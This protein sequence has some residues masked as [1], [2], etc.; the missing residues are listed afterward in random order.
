MAMT[1]EAVRQVVRSWL[2]TEVLSPLVTKDE[3][4]GLAADKHGR[5]RNAWADSDDDPAWSRPPGDDDPTPWTCHDGAMPADTAQDGSIGDERASASPALSATPPEPPRIWFSVVLAALPAKAAFERL[6]AI[7]RQEPEEETHRAAGSIIAAS[8][9]LDACGVLVPDSMAVASFAWGL[10]H[11]L[12][13]GDPEHLALWTEQEQELKRRFAGMLTPVGPGGRLRSLT[14]RDLR[15]ASAELRDALGIPPALWAATPCTIEVTGKLPPDADILSSFYLPDLDRVLRHAA[16]LPDAA[17]RYLGLRPPE[18]TWNPLADRRQLS[19]LLQPGLFPLARWPGPGLHPLTLLQQAA[20][21]AIA[22]DLDRTGLAAVNGPPGT[23]KTTLLRDLVA[24]VLVRRA[25]VLAGRDPRAG[26]DGMDLMDFAIVVA[27]SNNAAVENVSLELPV[28]DKALDASIWSGEGLDYFGHTANAVL[29]IEPDASAGERAWGLMAARLGSAANRRAFLND[30][31]W[32]ENWGL[33][34]WLNRAAWP[35]AP[36]NRQNPPGKLAQADPPPRAPEAMADWRAAR[37]GFRQALEHCRRLRAEA[38][39]LDAAGS[40]LREA[41][42]QAPMAAERIVIAEKD[43]H[44]AT[45]AAAAAARDCEMHRGQELIEAGK[46]AA[47][48]SVRPSRLGRL[49]RTRAWQAHEGQVR[50]Q[51]SAMTEAQAASRAAQARLADAIRQA[52]QCAWRRQA[53]LA[54]RDALLSEI[55]RLG[56]VRQR[57]AAAL[58]GALPEPGFWSQPD[59]AFYRASPWNGGAFR[60]ARD[61]VFVAAIRLHRAFIVA[62]AR[63]LKP[64]LNAVIKALQGGEAALPSAA[65]WGVFFLLTPVVSTTFAS[66]GRM[67]RGIGP[68]E[69]GWLMIDEA[70]QATPQAAAGAIWRARRAVVIGD[71]LQ[72]QPV[73][74]TPAQTTRLIFERFGADP[75]GWAAPVQS[76]QTLADRVSPIQG[77]FQLM[78]DDAGRDSRI[79]GMPLLVHRRCEQP[80]FGIANAIAYAGQM[81]FATPPGV[82]PIREV[83]GP[84][85]WIDVDAPCSGK[86]V[87]AE[88]Q[89][90]LLAIGALSIALQAT[91]NLYVVCPF[92]TPAQRLRALLRD[93]PAALPHLVKRAGREA[94]AKTHV[95]TVHTFQGKEAEAVILMLGAGRGGSAGSRAWAGRTPNLLNVAVTRARRAFYVVGNR[96]EWQG[97]G[98]FGT[99]ASLDVRS[100]LDWRRRMSALRSLH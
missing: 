68:G 39:A 50:G 46:L 85:A 74:A 76:A 82:S 21:N 73:A 42:A 65:D 66:I 18:Q 71:P 16:D 88:G 100:E 83:L 12:H 72:I 49:F 33:N 64:S 8:V 69:I 55:E 2:A 56:A 38:E 25:E 43:L 93:H 28:R 32:D 98:V 92:R 54:A 6:D 10:G 60:A 15:G 11:L 4:A 29:H 22:R 34:N 45:H 86:W 99:A 78:D 91:P 30:G 90:I 48:S 14:W 62:G 53:S 41:E 67:F 40:A 1:P 95:G 87:E 84:S 24:H 31:W 89:L 23:G 57:G 3:W 9:V 70:G 13:G 77:R 75:A 36:H 17:A 97:A 27:S 44:S 96:A 5:Q 47:L 7:F 19:S 51:V 52:E 35:D 20:V 58:D 79:T 61:A 59:D 37:D 63:A 26:L 94:W 80:M 81:V